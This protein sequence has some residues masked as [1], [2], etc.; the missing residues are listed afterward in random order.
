MTEQA[1]PSRPFKQVVNKIDTLDTPDATRV[2][3]GRPSSVA[4]DE[5]WLES[6]EGGE[7]RSVLDKLI[8]SGWFSL[9][10]VIWFGLIALTIFM[11]LVDL[12]PRAMH[13]DES[14]HA[15]FSYDYF[16]GINNTGAA[17]DPTWHGTL[18]YNLVALSYFLFGGVTET[19]A[20][21]APAIFGIILVAICYLLRPIVGRIGALAMAIFMMFSPSILYYGRS[22]RH[23]IFATVGE[24]L[25]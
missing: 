3:P 11:H 1:R 14:I 25:F 12:G 8:A 22:L 2:K 7:E 10:N 9:E 18:L 20:R 23:D 19:T 24:L 17:Y 13:H 5:E 16:R 15:S 4:L 21:M 6:E